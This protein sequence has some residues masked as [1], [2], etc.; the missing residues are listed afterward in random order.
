MISEARLADPGG[1]LRETVSSFAGRTGLSKTGI[2]RAVRDLAEYRLVESTVSGTDTLFAPVGP[3]RALLRRRDLYENGLI[4]LLELVRATESWP[5]ARPWGI[6]LADAGFNHAK[7][8]KARVADE[9]KE[10]TDAH[11]SDLILALCRQAYRSGRSNVQLLLDDA[12]DTDL[13]EADWQSLLSDSWHTL[14]YL[15]IGQGHILFAI[16][17]LEAPSEVDL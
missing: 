14:E 10:K 6:A 3:A 9:I 17:A 16:D 15:P 4:D 11:A 2:A 1:G 7:A 12:K 8:L 5:T 13:E